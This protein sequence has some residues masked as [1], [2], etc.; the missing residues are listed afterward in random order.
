MQIIRKTS[1]RLLIPAFVAVVL[2]A[3]L[4]AA[5]PA[6]ASGPAAP[7]LSATAGDGEVTLSWTAS[8]GAD[9]YQYRSSTDGGTSWLSDWVDVGEPASVR[10]ISVNAT[11]G[12]AYTFQVRAGKV[13]IQFGGGGISISPTPTTT[14][15]YSEPSNSVTVTPTE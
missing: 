6:P 4:L 12:T 11:N 10:E 3:L 2:A 1:W 15:R 13:Y 9:F 14:Y 7:T 8:A 5:P